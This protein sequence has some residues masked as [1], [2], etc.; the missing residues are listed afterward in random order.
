MSW[1]H[2]HADRLGINP[3]RVF[4]MGPSAGGAHVANYAYDRR[5]Q[6][7]GGHGLAGLILVSGRIRAD[8]A[9]DNPNAAK[10]I[11]YYG[12]PP[13]VHVAISAV[14]HVAAYSPPTLLAWADLENPL[15]D[16]HM[17]ELAHALARARRRSPP[18]VWLRGHNHTSSIAH[19]GS[20]DRQLE[21][22]I[23]DFIGNPR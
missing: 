6:P 21:L 9:P 17:A 22:A 8:T 14:T 12:T 15:I 1:V 23:A 2:A 16:I 10:V 3:G 20:S 11:A 18:L 4:L 13:P 19:L 5:L 7:E